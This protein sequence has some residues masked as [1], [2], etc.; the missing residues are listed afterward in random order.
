MEEEARKELEI[1]AA[2]AAELDRQ[3]RQKKED[4]ASRALAEFLAKEDLEREKKRKEQDEKENSCS[5]CCLPLIFEEG[6]FE[7]ANLKNCNCVLHIEC[8]R[9]HVAAQLDNNILTFTCPND[10]C[11]KPIHPIDLN[12]FMTEELMTKYNKLSL[13]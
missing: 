8:L 10:N 4:E 1:A 6:K 7:N 13:S 2:I 9:P 11:Q 12:K 3:E 5:I